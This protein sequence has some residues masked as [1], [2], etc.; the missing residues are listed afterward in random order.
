MNVDDDHRLFVV[1]IG[2]RDDGEVL[3]V[4]LHLGPKVLLGRCGLKVVC[5]PKNKTF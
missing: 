3:N 4:A 5:F 2:R 1:A